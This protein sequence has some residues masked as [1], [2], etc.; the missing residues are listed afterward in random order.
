[1]QYFKKACHSCNGF[2]SPP[3]SLVLYKDKF[4]T[5]T[6]LCDGIIKN[7]SR[8]RATVRQTAIVVVRKEFASRVIK[9]TAYDAV[10]AMVMR[11][12]LVVC[13]GIRAVIFRS[14]I[15]QFWGIA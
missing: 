13:I 15:L 14:V 6:L 10:A 11:E 2:F 4:L 8:N 3:P 5:K 7:L 1:M 12:Y 9:M